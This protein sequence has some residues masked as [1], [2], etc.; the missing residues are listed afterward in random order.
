MS[1]AAALADKDGDGVADVDDLDD[2]N[3]GILD[4][5]ESPPVV[6]EI[7]SGD[8]TTTV[9]GIFENDLGA[10]S[11]FEIV[12]GDPAIAISESPGGVTEGLQLRWN[13]GSTIDFDLDLTLQQPSSGILESVRVGSA[14]P[15]TTNGLANA[16]KFVTVTWQGGGNAVLSDPLGEIA[17]HADGAIIQSGDQFLIDSGLQLKDSAWALDVDVSNVSGPVVINFESEIAPFHTDPILNEGF[18]FIP[19]IHT[20]TDGDGVHDSCDLDSDNDGISDLIESGA[21]PLVV[22]VNNDGVYDGAVDPVTGI[23]VAANGGAGVDP[24]DSDSDGISDYI[25]LDSDNDGIADAIEAQPTAGYTTPAIGSD[26][27][28]DGVVDTFDSTTGHGGN[29]SL[30]EDTDGDNTPDYLDDDSDDDGALDSTESGLGAVT[31]ATFQDTDGSVADTST[32]LDNEAGDQ[33][34]VGFREVNTVPIAVDQTV[35]GTFETP[36]IITPLANDGDPDGDPLTIIAINGV[37]LTPGTAQTIAVLN[38]SVTVAVNGVITLTPENGFSGDIDVPYT[39]LLYTSPS[40]RDQRG[41]RMP[42][43]A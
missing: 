28:N 24:V 33:S 42:S 9:A 18:A 32:D 38:G 14:A 22:D 30:P 16:S 1:P 2:D 23:P 4:T 11:T 19:V 36:I 39:C 7:T 26:A 29:F 40:P 43:S 35:A 21:D 25:D 6:G 34:E 31:D 37:I 15:G 20:D 10:N 27:D 41:S 5:V 3:D 8:G 17:S 12:S 13:Q